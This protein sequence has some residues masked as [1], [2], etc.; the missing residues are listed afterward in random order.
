MIAALVFSASLAHAVSGNGVNNG[1]DA[2][3]CRAGTANR[4]AGTYS[5]DYLLTLPSFSSPDREL[6]AVSSW[7]QSAERIY[8]L[9]LE[10][11]PPAARGFD[12]FRQT[13]FN[14]DDYTKHRLWEP[15]DF[16]LVVLK[17]EKIGRAIPY[18]C[19]SGGKTM[20]VQAV[21]RLGKE[22]S[23]TDTIIYKYVPEVVERLEHDDPLQLSFL[24]VHE[25]LWDLNDDVEENRAA[26]RLL[27][28]RRFEMLSP[29][30]AA[31]ALHIK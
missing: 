1:G 19:K 21:L 15:S 27:H 29:D 17:D 22:F 6:A 9:L 5:L 28:S 26:N 7:G 25:W 3:Q 8:R 16:G 23:G 30:E 11:V 13:A 12:E 18:N 10:K 2:I 14:T 4:L 20:I 24:M 31:A